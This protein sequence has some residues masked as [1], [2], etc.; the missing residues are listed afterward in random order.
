MAEQGKDKEQLQG[1]LKYS[2]SLFQAIMHIV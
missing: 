2:I 1:Q